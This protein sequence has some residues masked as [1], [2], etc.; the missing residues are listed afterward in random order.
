LIE[1]VFIKK[2]CWTKDH[3]IWKKPKGVFICSSWLYRIV[4]RG[5]SQLTAL[6]LAQYLKLLLLNSKT[7]TLN[8]SAFKYRFRFMFNLS[9]RERG[10][11]KPPV[12]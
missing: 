1:Q 10:G 6:E 12:S 9:V 7:E 11:G 3:F 8:Q 5:T 2:L 4:L